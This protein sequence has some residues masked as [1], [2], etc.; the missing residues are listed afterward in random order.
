MVDAAGPAFWSNRCCRPLI[1]KRLLKLKQL[2][3]F[4]VLHIQNSVHLN[5]K[6]ITGELKYKWGTGF[7]VPVFAFWSFGLRSGKLRPDPPSLTTVA[8][9]MVVK[10]LRRDTQ[11]AAASRVL[12]IKD[13]ER[14]ISLKSTVF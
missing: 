12:G 1:I 2:F 6:V 7:K 4:T 10:K 3:S 5:Y 9:A 14:P 11:V 13:A 8:K